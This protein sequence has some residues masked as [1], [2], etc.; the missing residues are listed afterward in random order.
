[1]TKTNKITDDQI[2][3]LE[4]EAACALDHVQVGL[5]RIALTGSAESATYGTL[6]LLDEERSTLRKTSRRE[7]REACAE[8]INAARATES[9]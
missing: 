1:M 6:S 4:T 9:V 3:Q 8:A 5:C 7:A 2:E